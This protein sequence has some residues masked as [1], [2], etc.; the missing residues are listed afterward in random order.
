M[1]A[2]VA[3]RSKDAGALRALSRRRPKGAAGLHSTHGS[4]TGAAARFRAPA[5]APTTEDRVDR[6]RRARGPR[7]RAG[8]ALDQA[9]VQA[10]GARARRAD[11]GS[12]DP[13]GIRHTR[14]GRR[15]LLQGHP[16]GSRGHD[17][18]V[19]RR[20]LRVSE[21]GAGGTTAAAGIWR[22][23]GVCG[24]GLPVRSV[25]ARRQGLGRPTRRRARGRR[26]G[27]GDRPRRRSSPGG[28]RRS[29]TRS[30]RSRRP[31]ERRT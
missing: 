13:R 3:A 24:D 16:P 15:S 7:G 2:Q 26:G 10:P 31:A 17:C 1:F 30:C 28:T 21:S 23:G 14:Q 9:R 6:R 27:H 25:A 29:T 20:R 22:Q 12:D 4:G 18:P 5:R 19:R 11:D 8:E